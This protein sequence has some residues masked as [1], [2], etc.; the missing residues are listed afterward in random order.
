MAWAFNVSIV[1]GFT[2][3]EGLAPAEKAWYLPSPNSFINTSAITERAELPVQ[4]KRIFFI[5]D[6]LNVNAGIDK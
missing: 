3:P 2:A 6:I 4:I 1:R 5:D